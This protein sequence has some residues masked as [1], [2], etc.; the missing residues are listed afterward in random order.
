MV[1]ASVIMSVY[2]EKID[3]VKESIESIIHQ[4]FKD[5][6][7][8]I[9]LDKP[10]NIELKEYIHSVCESDNRVIFI[11]N[12]SNIGLTKSLNKA[13]SMSKGQY[14]IRMDADDISFKDRF[15]K[16][17][18]FMNSNQDILASGGS[19]EKFGNTSE[20][21]KI[22]TDS[23]KILEKFVIPSPLYPPLPH[24][25]AII[26]REVFFEMG[27]RYNEDFLVTQDYALWNTIIKIGKIGNL[28][29]IL[30]KYRITDNQ[31]TSNKKQLQRTNKSRIIKDHIEFFI[32]KN[33]KGNY[34]IPSKI[35]INE[36]KEL[37]VFQDR[38][39]L[40]FRNQLTNFIICYYLSLDNYSVSSLFYFLTQDFFNNGIP[41]SLKKTIVLNHIRKNPKII[42]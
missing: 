28:E 42:Q 20:L 15:E 8:L 30:L 7:F 13:I 12:E 11:I 27:V 31:I 14:I 41:N 4:T 23:I 10:D 17:I 29:D 36:I 25:T 37:K 35:T 21:L 33:T 34:K 3:W 24:P 26:R 19:I 16:Q 18:A 39:E 22:E 38:S 9:V 40:L 2:N 6:E 1:S 5:F 32:N